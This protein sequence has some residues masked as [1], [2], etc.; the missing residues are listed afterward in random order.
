MKTWKASFS[1][2]EEYATKAIYVG[3]F[4]IEGGEHFEILDTGARLI[5]GGACNVG[6]LESGF[7]E[8]DNEVETLDEALQELFADLT[9]Y[10]HDAGHNRIVCN[11]RM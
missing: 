8:Y 4:E 11:D 3:G 10:Y 2:M 7:M 1:T 9:A 5:F 6:F